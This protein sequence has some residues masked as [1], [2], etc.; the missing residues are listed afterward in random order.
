MSLVIRMRRLASLY[1][2]AAITSLELVA[3]V[4]TRVL[5]S[6]LRVKEPTPLLRLWPWFLIASFGLGFAIW[7]SLRFRKIF[8]D[9]YKSFY[10][11]RVCGA[12][13]KFM[14]DGYDWRKI[15]PKYA[16]SKW[17][18][19]K[20]KDL[21]AFEHTLLDYLS[22][23][24]KAEELLRRR[25]KWARLNAKLT[26]QFDSLLD[27]FKIPGAQRQEMLE[28]FSSHENPERRKSLLTSIESRLMRERWEAEHPPVP[29]GVSVLE[30]PIESRPAAVPGSRRREKMR[31]FASISREAVPMVE[32]KASVPQSVGK[33]ATSPEEVEVRY[34]SLQSFA[35]ERLANL[36]EFARESDWR[37]CREIIL[38]LARP[39][40]SGGRF[41][42]HY[43]AEDTV[44]RMVRRQCN[45][46][47]EVQFNPKT[48]D[49]A[50]KWLLAQKVLVTKPKVD[51][52]TLSLSTNVKN[53]SPQGA[54]IIKAFLLL[55]REMGGLPG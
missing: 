48:F 43:F 36:A 31:Y 2:I 6:S 1:G 21:V 19:Y 32:E 16:L 4:V 13:G 44:K 37:V 53:A 39:G 27:E 25:A 15:P 50:V 8:S 40:Q 55:K 9:A 54:K 14:N 49:E 51:E 33:Q 29:R 17:E 41:N 24:R 34:L 23:V 12:L 5:L 18:F 26:S 20:A 47:G 42:K 22:E 38:A 46:Y 3:A 11:R 45:M 52:R 35:R 28:D 7:T 30:S 10:A